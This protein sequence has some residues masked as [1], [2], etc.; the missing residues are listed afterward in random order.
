MLTNIYQTF[1]PLHS[2]WRWL[3]ILA[4][5]YVILK[6]ILGLKKKA[7][8]ESGGR[9]AALLYV[10]ALDI[11]FLIGVVLYA[12]SPIIHSAWGN[13]GAAMKVKELRYFAIEHAFLMIIA[14][15]L[16][17][18][19]T[20]LAKKAATD[21]AKYRRLLIFSSLSFIVMLAGIPWWRPLL[22]F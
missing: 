4:G 5:L 19:G 9:M 15:A 20:V 18:V 21:T 11:Q 12:L 16:A 7:S 8:F 10:S 6:C 3:V 2:G 1:L 22:R 17:H 14:I 13:I